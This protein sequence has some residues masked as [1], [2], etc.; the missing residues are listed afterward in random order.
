MNKILKVLIEWST[1]K[2][3]EWLLAGLACMLP[4]LFPIWFRD[5]IASL[6]SRTQW[7]ILCTAL[8]SIILLLTFY[9]SSLHRA[10]SAKPNRKDYYFLKDPPIWVHLKDHTFH[11]PK[12]LFEIGH[13]KSIMGNDFDRGY[14]CTNCDKYYLDWEKGHRVENNAIRIL[15][16]I[17]PQKD[18]SL[19]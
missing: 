14:R 13:D 5:Q 19:P 11:C 15:F 4:I 17:E 9:I 12:C 7:S 1:T 6:L 8:I 3:L 16:H 2:I 18:S 10:I